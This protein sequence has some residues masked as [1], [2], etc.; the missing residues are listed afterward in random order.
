MSNE[1]PSFTRAKALPEP[2]RSHFPTDVE[3]ARE[4]QPH[5]T[6]RALASRVLVVAKT[7]IECAWCAYCDAVP[8]EDHSRELDAVLR[9]GSKLD[10][11]I[12]RA[13][14]PQFEGIPYAY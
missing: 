1:H 8:G 10:E 3:S 9:H 7:R 14:F 2:Y 4:F 6:S 13:L 11:R 5:V 12:A